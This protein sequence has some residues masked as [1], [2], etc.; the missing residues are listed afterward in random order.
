M[1]IYDTIRLEFGT[2]SLTI[3]SDDDLTTSFGGVKIRMLT[4]TF[5]EDDSEYLGNAESYEYYKPVKGKFDLKITG[6]TASGV[7]FFY[8]RLHELAKLPERYINEEVNTP[9][10][11]Y[12]GNSRIAVLRSMELKSWDKQISLNDLKAMTV[13]V[14]YEREPLIG[15]SL[16]Y[17]ATLVLSSRTSFVQS[18]KQPNIVNSS[19]MFG[20]IPSPINMQMGFA[21]MKT[22]FPSGFFLMSNFKITTISGGMF[23]NTSTYPAS[24]RQSLIN[25]NS[26]F[27]YSVYDGIDNHGILRTVPTTLNTSIISSGIVYGN[28]T[29]VASFGTISSKDVD[30]YITYRTTFSGTLFDVN[31]IANYTNFNNSGKQTQTGYRRLAHS[32]T[33]NVAYIGRISGDYGIEYASLQLDIKAQNAISGALLIDRVVLHPTQEISNT[34]FVS[35]ISLPSITPAYPDSAN[36]FGIMYAEFL[37]SYV[38]NSLQDRP[39]RP[40]FRIFRESGV[41]SKVPSYRGSINLYAKKLDAVSYSSPGTIYDDGYFNILFLSTGSAYDSVSGMSNWVLTNNFNQEVKTLVEFLS[42]PMR[43]NI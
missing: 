6:P 25:E 2:Y 36:S 43:T 15:G 5:E 10:L 1:G 14:E 27:A 38:N 4:D 29:S 39:P 35:K 41:A 26:K 19:S 24:P 11:L 22:T 37:N 30:A 3:G 34:V 23:Y 20:S 13:S 32:S 9:L 21:D 42:T 40:S 7:L 16:A 31:L 33:P 12:F 17:P 28:G 18:I 8:N